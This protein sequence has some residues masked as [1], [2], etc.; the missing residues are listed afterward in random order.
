MRP[1]A[2]TLGLAGLALIG[3]GAYFAIFGDDTG[4]NPVAGVMIRS[5][6][7]LAAVGLVLPTIRKP[8][9]TTN[10]SLVLDGRVRE[11]LHRPRSLP[12]GELAY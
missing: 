6:A 2:L 4:S 1:M 7:V 5:G 3:L 9:V 11:E 8:S 10:G 12:E